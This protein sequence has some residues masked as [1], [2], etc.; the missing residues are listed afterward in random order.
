MTWQVPNRGLP[1]WRQLGGVC[2]SAS[3]VAARGV[4]SSAAET[5]GRFGVGE[6]SGL[7]IVLG[8]RLRIIVTD[9]LFKFCKFCECYKKRI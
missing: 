1:R 8:E 4:S 6:V 7:G 5:R 2:A 3:D 9:P